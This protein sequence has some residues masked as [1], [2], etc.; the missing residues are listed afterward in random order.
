MDLITAGPWVNLRVWATD[1]SPYCFTPRMTKTNK[2]PRQSDDCN[3]LT[4]IWT[5]CCITS[6]RCG[7][8]RIH[9]LFHSLIAQPQ[10]HLPTG[11]ASAMG[12]C[13]GTVLPVGLCNGTVSELCKRYKFPPVTWAHNA[14]GHEAIPNLFLNQPMPLEG[15]R[16]MSHWQSYGH[17]V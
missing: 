4:Q 3:G 11:R 9:S 2:F 13:N 1:K 12:L 10:R 14:E 16:Q 7:F 5:E 8:V 17:Q 6:W 15:W